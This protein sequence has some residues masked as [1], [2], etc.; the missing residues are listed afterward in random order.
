MVGKRAEWVP[1]HL[2]SFWA[3]YSLQEGMLNGLSFG[4]GVRYVGST[5]SYGLD[6]LSVLSGTPQELY[7]KTPSYTLFDAMVAYETPDWR[8]QLTA[9]NLED[10]YYVTT[11]SAY[12]GDCGVGQARTIISGFT[13]KF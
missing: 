13:Y 3:I 5:E 8:W 10:E 9:Q 2:A 7:V 12:R 6:V 11:C 1:K 4:A